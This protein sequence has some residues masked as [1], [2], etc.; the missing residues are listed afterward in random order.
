MSNVHEILVFL[1]LFSKGKKLPILDHCRRQVGKYSS[2]H[3]TQ[4]EDEYKGSHLFGPFHFQCHIF[5]RGLIWP[6]CMGEPLC[7]QTHRKFLSCK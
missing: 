1:E 6:I 3:T 4:K 7:G 2:K 5:F